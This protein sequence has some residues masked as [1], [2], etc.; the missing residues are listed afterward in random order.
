MGI[1]DKFKDLTK[2]AED[3]AVE[4]QDQILDAI[5]TSQDAVVS[6]VAALT[7]SAAP[8]TEKL[9]APPFADLVANPVD[10]TDSYFSFA[11]KLLASQKDFT[12]KLA[13]SYRPAKPA[14]KTG[15]K[16]A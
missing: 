7:D 5:K 13:E 9:P 11:Q 16:G 10:V 2:K 12:L 4:H 1:A 8:I 15:P 3:A 6:A 14:A